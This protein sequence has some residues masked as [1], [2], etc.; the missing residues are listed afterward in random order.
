MEKFSYSAS[1]S[2]K[3]SA[4]R[5]AKYGERARSPPNFHRRTNSLFHSRYGKS[6]YT[7]LALCT[8][9]SPRHSIHTDLSETRCLPHF[10]HLFAV[11]KSMRNRF[12]L[13]SRQIG[14]TNVKFPQTKH[15]SPPLTNERTIRPAKIL[16][17]LMVNSTFFIFILVI[18]FFNANSEVLTRF[19]RIFFRE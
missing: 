19:F 1:N 17:C 2:F 10:S 16:C 11:L 13:Q 14:M 8:T 7:A 4:Q 6:G 9:P 3:A 5:L 12:F 18:V 15:F